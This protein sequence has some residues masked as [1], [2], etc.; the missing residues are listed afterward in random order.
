MKKILVIIFLGLILN[1]TAFA[2][3]K[4]EKDLKKVSKDNGF[5]DSKG[6]TYSIDQILDKNNTILIIF[7]HGSSNDQKIDK[8]LGPSN[9][10]PPVIR[11]LHDKKIK[12]FNVKIYRDCQG[13]P[14]ADV[15]NKSLIV[16]NHPSIN[17]I[18]LN[19]SIIRTGFSAL[20]LID[21]FFKSKKI[22]TLFKR[23]SNLG[24]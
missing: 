9:K 18:S 3:K 17:S 15:N 8:C 20:S 13:V 1:T 10:V 22:F 24:L 23:I 12:N 21:I 4:F 7:N 2:D 16:H 14:L 19:L 6:K 11:N 5:V